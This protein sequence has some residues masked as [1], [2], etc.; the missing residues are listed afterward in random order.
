M[1][2][3]LVDELDDAR[4]LLAGERG[5]L[6]RAGP[7]GRRADPAAERRPRSALP[8]RVEFAATCTLRKCNRMLLTLRNFRMFPVRNVTMQILREP[9]FSNSL[10]KRESFSTSLFVCSSDCFFLAPKKKCLPRSNT[11]LLHNANAQRYKCFIVTAENGTT[12]KMVFA[13]LDVFGMFF[14]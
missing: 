6:R 7:R 12:E 13:F 10:Y 11:I 8:W 4:A 1:G 14:L 5:E 3:E 9:K 2:G